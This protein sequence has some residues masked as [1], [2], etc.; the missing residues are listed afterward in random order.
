MLHVGIMRPM[1][2][3]VLV[4]G[5]IGVWVGFTFGRSDSITTNIHAGL[6]A[7]IGANLMFSS[8]VWWRATP[9]SGDAKVMPTVMLI[10]A[11]MLIGILPRVLWPSN[12]VSHAVGSIASA[13]IVTFLAFL[14]IR[15]RRRLRD[16]Q[17]AI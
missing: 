16:Q 17:R 15:K 2:W 4:A 5:M 12:D 11:A 13:L 8:W 1:L 10:S 6:A 3:L 7:L 9:G 14:Q